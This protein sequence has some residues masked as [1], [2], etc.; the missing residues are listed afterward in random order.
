MKLY[1]WIENEK[2]IV[3]TQG[4][5]KV[6][7]FMLEYEEGGQDWQCNPPEHELRIRFLVEKNSPAI[8]IRGNKAFQIIDKR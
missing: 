2:G 1:S 6:L 3:K 5:N 7:E 4:G 8:Y